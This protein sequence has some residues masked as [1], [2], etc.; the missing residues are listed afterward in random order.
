LYVP[1]SVNKALLYLLAKQAFASKGRLLFPF[2]NISTKLKY[3][4]SKDSENLP[5]Q[6]K[7]SENLPLQSK[8]SENLPLQSKAKRKQAKLFFLGQS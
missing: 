5:L 1:L 3:K 2:A 8:D 6:S 7:D 4:Q